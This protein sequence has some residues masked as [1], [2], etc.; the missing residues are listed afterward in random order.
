[1]A[2]IKCSECTKDISDKAHACPNCG[3]PIAPQVAIKRK[4]DEYMC[5]P[6]CASKEVHAEQKGF[7][8][9]KALAGAVVAGGIGLLAGTIGSKDVQ[10]TCLKCGCKFKAGDYKKEKQKFDEE[11]EFN[12]KMA[13]GDVSGIPLIVVLLVLTG[14]GFYISFLLLTNEWYFLGSIFSIATLLCFSM[15]IFCIMEENKRGKK[16]T[17]NKKGWCLFEKPSDN[18]L[19]CS[20]C[21]TEL[22]GKF[23]GI[24]KDDS[25][26]SVKM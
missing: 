22:W 9:G 1:M 4:D 24:K 7:S 2:L 17:I 11:K 12:K 14:I 25:N 26:C 23:D 10:I 6:K 3:N 15:M 21:G 18:T 8:G 5:C 20:K 19:I 13:K 16:K